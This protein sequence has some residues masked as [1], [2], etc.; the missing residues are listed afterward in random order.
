[1]RYATNNVTMIGKDTQY[2][3]YLDVMVWAHL[4][5]SMK[6]QHFHLGTQMPFSKGAGSIPLIPGYLIKPAIEEVPEGGIQERFMSMYCFFRFRQAGPGKR[7]WV[8]R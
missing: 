2:K 1:M 7:R 4:L 6:I 3:G 5:K 8:A